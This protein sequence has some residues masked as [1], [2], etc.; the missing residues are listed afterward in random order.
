MRVRSCSNTFIVHLYLKN[1][2]SLQDLAPISSRYTSFLRARPIVLGWHDVTQDN[3]AAVVHGFSSVGDNGDHYI[4]GSS[5]FYERKALGIRN[6]LYLRRT[7]IAN[8]ICLSSFRVDQERHSKRLIDFVISLFIAIGFVI[9][10]E[11]HSVRE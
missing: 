2:V 11:G 9:A 10:L 7:S 8:H 5:Y 6:H 3:S 4:S 1:Y